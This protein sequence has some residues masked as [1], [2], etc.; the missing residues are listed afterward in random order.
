MVVEKRLKQGQLL[1]F[2]VTIF[3]KKPVANLLPQ[4]GFTGI[5]QPSSVCG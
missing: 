4:G 2:Y 3:G 1:L 5:N